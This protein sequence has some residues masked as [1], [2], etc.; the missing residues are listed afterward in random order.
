MCEKKNVSFVRTKGGEFALRVTLNAST[1]K[2]LERINIIDRLPGIVKIYEKFSGTPPDK[3]DHQSRRIQWNIDSLNAGESR[4]FSYI[5]YSKVGVVG[6]FELPPAIGVYD[7]EGKTFHV[8]S[9]KAFFV[10]E[11]FKR[12][13][14]E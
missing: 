4:V 13:E 9:N 3:V 7:K 6:R 1:K 2:Y 14:G 12:P 5:L 8:R 10:H 11:A